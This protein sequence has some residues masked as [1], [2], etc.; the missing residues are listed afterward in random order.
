MV[1]DPSRA[2]GLTAFARGCDR[3]INVSDATSAEGLI[4]ALMGNDRA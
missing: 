4:A 1:T 2:P 3:S